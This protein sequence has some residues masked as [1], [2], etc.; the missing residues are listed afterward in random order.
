MTA[1][2]PPALVLTAGLG[3]RLRPLTDRLAKPALPVGDDALVIRVLRHLAAQGIRDAVL[4][5]HHLPATVARVVGDGGGTGVKVRYSW[6]QPRLLG[7]GGGIRHALP[8]VDGDTLLVVNGDSMCDLPLATLVEDHHRTG[9]LVTLGLMP[10][11]VE[12]KYGG[13]LLSADGVVTGFPGRSSELHTWHYP[14]IQVVQRRAFEGL[15]DNEPVE[16]VREVYPSL[17]SRWPGCVRGRVF[18]ASWVDV[19]TVDD[20]LAT[21]SQLAG[22]AAGNVVSRGASVDPSA[23]LARTV[24]WPGGRVEAGCRLTACVVTDGAVVRAGTVADGRVFME[25][26]LN[27]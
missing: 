8:L 10:H 24:V 9:A 20:Y 22:D 21:C 12:R 26:H 25:A 2:P 19:G 4:N 1:W 13:V 16:S 18:E 11:P 15:P 7:S 14:G 6:E 5:L 27:H 17:M 23:V 3:T